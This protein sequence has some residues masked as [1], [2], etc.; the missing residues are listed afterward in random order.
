M[1]KTKSAIEAQLDIIDIISEF[2]KLI[3]TTN[4]NLSAT[5]ENVSFVDIFQLYERIES[6]YKKIYLP[7]EIGENKVIIIYVLAP[8]ISI[9]I[10][11]EPALKL[12]PK[13]NLI[14]YN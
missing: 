9:T 12:V 6:K 11:S 2:R 10:Q 13:I 4:S 8:G 5:I 7:Q 1:E 14:N 3:K